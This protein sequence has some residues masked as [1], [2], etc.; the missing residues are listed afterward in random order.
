MVEPYLIIP[1]V[2]HIFKRSHH[3][4]W[5]TI[6]SK[7]RY[8]ELMVV[9]RGS[10]TFVI[11]GTIY[12]IPRGNAALIS[13][14]SSYY[15]E[16]QQDN[17][18]V[19]YACHFKC[20]HMENMDCR[21]PFPNGLIKPASER[22]VSLFK[23]M[24]YSFLEK[25]T[26]YKLET[27]A[28]LQL[29]IAELAT[30]HAERPMAALSNPRVI[31]MKLHI[32]RHLREKVTPDTIRKITG[33]NPDYF[34][35]LFKKDTGYTIQQYINRCRIARAMDLL[36]SG[37]KKVG[38]ISHLC[39]VEDELYFTKLFNKRTGMSPTEYRKNY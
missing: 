20:E 36:T 16:P 29:I 9:I 25:N 15:F 37:N 8:H 2:H 33:L 6:E 35:S 23:Q 7:A 1:K 24:H 17:T 39:G 12:K 10:V 26:C 34:A 5:T 32:K 14:G 30:D 21:L 4:H 13:Q 31:Q 19:K 11:D 27:S 28:Y 3:P 18:F 22:V 38:E